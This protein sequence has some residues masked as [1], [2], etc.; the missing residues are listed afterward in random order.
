MEDKQVYTI[1]YLKYC[2]TCQHAHECETE[3]KCVAC[4]EEK[5]LLNK[6]GE[7]PHAV[8]TEELLRAYA[9]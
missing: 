1:N 9:E 3:G 6:D 4:W 5:G 8:T 2:Y 7:K